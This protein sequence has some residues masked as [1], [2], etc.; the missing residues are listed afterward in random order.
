MNNHH[1]T[2]RA[3]IGPLHTKG[4]PVIH[5][6][7]HEAG[8]TCAEFGDIQSWHP[9]DQVAH[10][11]AGSR[12]CLHRLAPMPQ[13]QLFGSAWLRQL[14]RQ[15]ATVNQTPVIASLHNGVVMLAFD[16]FG[17]VEGCTNKPHRHFSRVPHETRWYYKL[18]PTKWDD[19]PD[20]PDAVDDLVLLGV[21][22]T[23]VT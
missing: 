23:E 22:Q 11:V 20:L 21:L 8:M 6:Q 13:V 12:P 18:H 16:M 1:K 3:F 14:P 7:I 2:K 19:L 9:R 17:P 15:P 10:E 4:T 5:L